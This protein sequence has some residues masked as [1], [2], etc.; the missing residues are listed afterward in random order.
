MLFVP[1]KSIKDTIQTIKILLDKDRGKGKDLF[2]M[3]IDF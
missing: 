1:R 3:L 2:L